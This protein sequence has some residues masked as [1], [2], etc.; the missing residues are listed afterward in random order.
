MS[1]T[2]AVHNVTVWA[3]GFG[4]W[5]ASVPLTGNPLAD[6]NKARTLII[7]ELA[8]REGPNFDPKRVHVTRTKITGHGTAVYSER[9]DQD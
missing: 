2:G 1:D 7:D 8:Q 9:I 5:H 6:A 3:D 4:H